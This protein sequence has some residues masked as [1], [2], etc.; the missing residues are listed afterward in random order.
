MN[1]GSRK[2]KD[3]S[4]ESTATQPSGK[5]R[6]PAHNARDGATKRRAVSLGWALRGLTTTWRRRLSSAVILAAALLTIVAMSPAALQVLRPSH[7]PLIDD[8]RLSQALANGVAPPP[9]Q[10]G[11]ALGYGDADGGRPSIVYLG[12]ETVPGTPVINSF[13]D[14]P[15]GRPDERTFLL[16]SRLTSL[17]FLPGEK[18]DYGRRVSVVQGNPAVGLLVPM[19]NDSQPQKDCGTLR[20]GSVATDLH[21]RLA[22]WDTPEYD[23]HVVRA[24]VTAAN[25]TPHWITDAVLVDSKPGMKLSL[26]SASV[27]R[28]LPVIASLP[29][30]G[31]AALFRPAGVVVADGLLGACWDNRLVVFV[32]LKA[33]P[34]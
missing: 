26:V 4:E 28:K 15:Y 3:L 5:H 27:Y 24:W 12:Q 9:G 20:G 6:H 18:L 8:T 32:V 30:T 16:V 33:A 29:L 22:T 1:A 10:S 13:V 34:R 11:P 7:P 25:S 19:D 14:L 21:L 2:R 23:Q 17:K 31:A